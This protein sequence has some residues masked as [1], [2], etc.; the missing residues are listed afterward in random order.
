MVALACLLTQG[1]PW[2]DTDGHVID[3]HGGGMLE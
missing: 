1:E 2:L 3:A